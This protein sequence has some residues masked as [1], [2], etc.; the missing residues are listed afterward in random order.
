MR[1]AVQRAGELADVVLPRLRPELQRL[2]FGA[3]AALYDPEHGRVHVLNETAARI[4]A[5]CDG[6]TT[7]RALADALL[8][9]Y[10]D[11]ELARALADI[12]ITV[13][14]FEVKHLVA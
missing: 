3:E 9:E 5:H 4:A 10:A 12:A 7:A 6:Q 14:A 8:R 2:E 11:L 13:E 1:N